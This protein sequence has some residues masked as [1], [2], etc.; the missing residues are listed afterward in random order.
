MKS[1]SIA[2][3]GSEKN[4]HGRFSLQEELSRVSENTDMEQRAAL[5]NKVKAVGKMQKYYDKLTETNDVALKLK[6]YLEPLLFSI[7]YYTLY[8]DSV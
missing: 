3:K 8:F 4:I 5:M 1:Y 6:G 2:L 7:H